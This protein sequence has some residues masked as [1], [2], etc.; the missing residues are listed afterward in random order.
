[1]QARLCGL[2]VDMKDGVVDG[3]GGV[4]EGG[5]IGVGGGIEGGISRT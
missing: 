5:V 3:R 4:V 1:M 2:A